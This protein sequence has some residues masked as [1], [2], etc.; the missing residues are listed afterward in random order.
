MVA[1][2]PITFESWYRV[3][4]SAVGL[5]PSSSYVDVEG[6]QVVVRMGWAFRTRFP[7][8]AVVSVSKLG[9][10]PVSRGVHGF[11]G[12]WLVNGSGDGITSLE[13]NPRQRAYVLGLPVGLRE[14]QVSVSN[15]AGLAEA[16][17]QRVH[18]ARG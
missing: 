15:P 17:G 4:S 2:F 3:F 13:L 6:D 16:V 1:H 12:R 5:L 9:R 7:R 18:P 14:L 10:R 11:A 8:S